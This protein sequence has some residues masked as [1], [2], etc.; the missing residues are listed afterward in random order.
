MWRDGCDAGE[1][2]FAEVSF[3]VVFLGV[4]EA[5][6]GHDGLLAGFEAGFAGEVFGGVGGGAAVEALVVL[7]G[8]VH[9]HE[10]GGFEFHPVFGEGV[11]DGLVLADGA[12]EDVAVLGVLGGAFEGD[13]AEADGFGGDEDSFGVEAVED[14]FEAPALF[15]DEVFLGDDE[16]VDEELVRVDGFAAHFV[17]FAD[18]DAGAV[19]FGVEEAEAVCAFFDVFE[20]V[21]RARRSMRSATWAVLIQTFR[22]LAM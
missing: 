11:L 17:D 13:E 5:A 15:A 4:S 8:G 20:G 3:D 9:G 7:P 12:A 14:V 6:V 21:V 19:E 22:P 10:A 18:F 2:D 16:V 1:D